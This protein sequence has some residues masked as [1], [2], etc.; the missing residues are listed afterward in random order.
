MPMP[1]VSPEEA[2]HKF[3]PPTAVTYCSKLWYDNNFDL[4]ITP[5]R[6]T[7]LGDYKYDF[8]KKTHTISVNHDLNRYG[9]L[10]TYLHEI[11]HL[12]TFK[13]Y[14]TR[15]LPHGNEWKLEFQKL[16]EP[17]LN[18]ETFPDKIFYAL[19]KY[20]SNPKASSCSDSNLLLA[21]RS[22]DEKESK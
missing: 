20:M 9:F 7:K 17:I 5:K 6:S 22:F 4:K 21:I 19:S 1:K 10:I 2:F 3:V 14:S 12:K 8:L 16:V 11:A 15:V 13:K 18:K